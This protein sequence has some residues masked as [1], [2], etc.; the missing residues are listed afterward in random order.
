MDVPNIG[1]LLKLQ[2]KTLAPFTLQIYFEIYFKI[3]LSKFFFRK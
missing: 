2:L 1:Q 3:K